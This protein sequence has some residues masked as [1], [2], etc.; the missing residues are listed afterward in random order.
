MNNILSHKFAG[1]PSPTFN[2]VLSRTS[3]GI[4]RNNQFYIKQTLKK[5][6]D[7]SNKHR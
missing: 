1:S 4:I 2:E 7:H 3:N 5:Q 6:Y